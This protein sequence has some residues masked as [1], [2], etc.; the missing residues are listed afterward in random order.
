VWILLRARGAR[1]RE[2]QSFAKLR[3]Y[4]ESSINDPEFGFR[5]I[6]HYVTTVDIAR[7]SLRWKVKERKKREKEKREGERENFN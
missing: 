2:S 6:P 4:A 5:E 7:N 3:R 1:G